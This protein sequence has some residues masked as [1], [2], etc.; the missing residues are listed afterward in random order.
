MS[1]I[2]LRNSYIVTSKLGTVASGFRLGFTCRD[3]SGGIIAQHNKSIRKFAT[4]VRRNFATLPKQHLSL[5]NSHLPLFCV[6]LYSYAVSSSHCRVMS[7]ISSALPSQDNGGVSTAS[8]VPTNNSKI[9]KEG[10]ATMA[11]PPTDEVFY[12]PVQVQNR[13]LSIL[14]IALHAER[15]S[16]RRATILAKKAERKRLLEEAGLTEAESRKKGVSQK[17]FAVDMDAISKQM[18]SVDWTEK[19]KDDAKAGRPPVGNRDINVNHGGIRILDALAASGLRSIRYA[20]EIPGVDSV[21]VNDLDE[22]AIE[23]AHCNIASNGCSSEEGNIPH[24]TAHVG[25]AIHH[26]YSCMSP[27]KQNFDVIDIDPY[28][29]AAPFLDAAV[30]TVANGG[31]LC[32]TCTDMAAMSGGHPETCYGRLGSM[33]VPKGKYCQELAI[34]LTLAAMATIAGRCGRTI[35]PV[36]SVGMAFYIRCFVEIWDDKATISVQAKESQVLLLVC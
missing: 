18:D 26:M 29:T 34:R 21:V 7:S 5:K 1:G 2:F 19:V 35:R 24:I 30:R 32:V 3:T 31:M 28:G 17:A 25:D 27:S 4:E 36:L 10:S 9:I 23:L 14:M 33:P 12:N 20:K 22:A 6:R 16:R 11:Y 13:D 15:R 8:S